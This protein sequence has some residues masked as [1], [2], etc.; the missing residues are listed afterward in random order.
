MSRQN[1]KL[2]ASNSKMVK[3]NKKGLPFL[4]HNG[5]LPEFLDA[6]EATNEGDRGLSAFTKSQ[7]MDIDT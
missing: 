5:Q 4:M 1:S 6:A 7:N 2:A 3:K